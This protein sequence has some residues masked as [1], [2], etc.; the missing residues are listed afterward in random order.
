MS[1]MVYQVPEFSGENVPIAVVAKVMKK[2]PLF[3]REAMKQGLLDIG[4]CFKK[5]DSS[6]YDYYVSPKK[7]WEATG[8]I[9]TEKGEP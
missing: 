7:L 6:Q 8:Y 9:Y 5:P 2:D 3:I 4:V 1:E